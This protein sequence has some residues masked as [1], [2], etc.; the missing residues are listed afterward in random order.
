MIKQLVI[1][2]KAG[3]KNASGITFNPQ[4]QPHFFRHKEIIRSIHPKISRRSV[5]TSIPF[6]IAKIHLQTKKINLKK[7]TPTNNIITRS[8][9]IQS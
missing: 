9:N 4:Q 6:I 2:K 7:Q 1:I 8:A 3:Y 5:A